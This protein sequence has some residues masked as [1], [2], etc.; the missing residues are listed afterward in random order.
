MINISYQRET[1]TFLVESLDLGIIQH[2]LPLRVDFI[3]IVTGDIGYSAELSSNSW[4]S[5][6]GAEI[7]HDI[8]IFTN[9]GTLLQESKW[10][11]SQRGDSIERALWF[12]LTNRKNQNIASNGLVIGTHDGRNG[13]WIYAVKE[14]ITR[15]TLIEGSANQFSKL[16]NNYQHLN[17]VRMINTIVTTNG[18]DVTWYSGGEGYYDTVIA[19]QIDDWVSKDDLKVTNRSSKSINQIMSEDDFDWLHL[20]VEGIDD[21]LVYCL[22][23]LPNLIIYECLN[24]ELERI[25]NLNTFLENKGYVIIESAGNVMALKPEL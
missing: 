20:D 8:K 15:A 1:N 25:K 18:Q 16:K 11:V 19:G 13:H 4:I 2:L 22:D 6:K 17:N 5:W 21:D 12:Y 3:D 23:K 7:I 9:K 24:F 14:N 10:D